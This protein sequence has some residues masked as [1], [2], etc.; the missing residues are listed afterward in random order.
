MFRAIDA[1]ERAMGLVTMDALV[2]TAGDMLRSI[3]GRFLDPHAGIVTEMLA[4]LAEKCDGT[5]LGRVR[6]IVRTAFLVCRADAARA[7]GL[8]DE[9]EFAA[10]CLSV[11]T[12]GR[13]GSR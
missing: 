5:D 11:P 6:W 12:P 8:A 10:G 4:R 3:R 2:V 1:T 13:D 7:R 9:A